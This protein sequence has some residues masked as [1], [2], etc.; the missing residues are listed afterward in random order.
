[1]STLNQLEPEL[2]DQAEA[3]RSEI[4]AKLSHEFRTPLTAIQE[5]VDILLDG[6]AGP[7]QPRQLEFLTLA[8]RN[9]SRLKK[10][11]DDLLDL[12]SLQKGS[13][14]LRMVEADLWTIARLAVEA[15]QA[16]GQPITLE[17]TCE[18]RLTAALVDPE[19][20]RQVVLRLL[21]NVAVHSGCEARVRVSRAGDEVV[22]EV[23][24]AGPGIP[25]DKIASIFEAFSQL[26]TGPGR[27]VGGAGLGLTLAKHFIERQGGR[28]WLQ[29]RP[30]DGTR[31]FVA[32]KATAS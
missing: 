5:S 17:R 28:L 15:R 14:P 1:M 13:I 24:D 2:L 4:V 16:L 12:S 18:P 30:G 6:L 29:S 7:L 26:S 25:E 11:I 10:L 21:E 19:R 23:A 3:E 8:R 27:K 31:F 9:V 20:T 32:L 22:V